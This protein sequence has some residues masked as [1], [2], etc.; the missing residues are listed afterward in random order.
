VSQVKTAEGLRQEYGIDD[1]GSV[2]DEH[3]TEQ[4]LAALVRAE[5]PPIRCVG[6]DWSV[7]QNGL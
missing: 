2:L 3:A 1:C 5:L 4:Q 7:Y 6:E